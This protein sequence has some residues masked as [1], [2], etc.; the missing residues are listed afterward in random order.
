MIMAVKNL[1][2]LYN[3]AFGYKAAPF[4]N[5]G[6]AAYVPEASKYNTVGIPEYTVYR[7]SFLGTAFFMPI[8]IGDYQ[9]PNEPII[10][11][12]GGKTIIKTPIDNSDGTFK[13]VFSLNDYVITIKGIAVD[14]NNPDNYPEEQVRAIRDLC[15]AKTNLAV[16]NRLCSYFNI[17]YLVIESFSFP[18]IEGSRDMQPYVLNCISDKIYDLVIKEEV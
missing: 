1:L 13:E 4:K 7:Q 8:A 12:S 3:S 2:E 9:L 15:E 17:N 14:D 5:S 16:V 10:E 18:T 6:V 11:I